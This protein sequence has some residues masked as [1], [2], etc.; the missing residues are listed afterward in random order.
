MGEF[1]IIVR[2]PKLRG[3][4]HTFVHVTYLDVLR[5]DM[6]AY[7]L[8]FALARAHTDPRP[9]MCYYVEIPCLHHHTIPYHTIPEN[10]RH[11]A[12][13]ETA[14]RCRAGCRAFCQMRS[15]VSIA[16]VPKSEVY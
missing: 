14:E 1:F 16:S 4:T 10:E 7:A 12:T 2:G 11:R 13:T 5:L 3:R 15:G 8:A 6:R 9:I